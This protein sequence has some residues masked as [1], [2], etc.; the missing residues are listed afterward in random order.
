[1]ILATQLEEHP[2]V[3]PPVLPSGGEGKPLK[4]RQ[5]ILMLFVLPP[6]RS[7]SSR[8]DIDRIREILP[9]GQE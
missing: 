4:I 6:G 3:A 5:R 2:A 9:I 1:M 8:L 7:R